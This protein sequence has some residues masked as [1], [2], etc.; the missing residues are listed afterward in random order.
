MW[1]NAFYS[2]LDRGAVIRKAIVWKATSFSYQPPSSFLKTLLDIDP[3]V[4]RDPDV[5]AYAVS[6]K[7]ADIAQH[8]LDGGLEANT[9]APTPDL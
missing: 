6:R 1:S 2:Y 3:K 8:I 4:T 9:T 5:L 7:V